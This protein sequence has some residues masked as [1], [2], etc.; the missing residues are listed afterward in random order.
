[1]DALSIP[2][3]KAQSSIGPDEVHV[4]TLPLPRIPECPVLAELIAV[5]MLLAPSPGKQ[6]DDGVYGW[7]RH[8][9]LALPPQN[10]MDLMEAVIAFPN[11]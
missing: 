8:S 1:M 10:A 7:R 6:E 5:A 2:V 9:S 11:L 3:V 4:P